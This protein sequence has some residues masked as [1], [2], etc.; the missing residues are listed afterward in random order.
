MLVWTRRPNLPVIGEWYIYVVPKPPA[1][2]IRYRGFP[3]QIVQVNA[4]KG[5]VTLRPDLTMTVM[6][7]Q[8]D[9]HA[10]IALKSFLLRMGVVHW[11]THQNLVK[12]VEWHE[13]RAVVF[14][15]SSQLGYAVGCSYQL[16]CGWEL[17]RW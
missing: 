1:K 10:V 7:E 13:V 11:T 9:I 5:Q 2:G 14:A 12:R 3:A 6:P 16:T 4:A 17:E 15:L 8:A